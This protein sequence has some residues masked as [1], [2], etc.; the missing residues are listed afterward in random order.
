[1]SLLVIL[2]CP[3][4]VPAAPLSRRRWEDFFL[5]G[6]QDPSNAIAYWSDLSYGQYD[7]RGS[8]VVDWINIGHTQA[9]IASFTGTE[10]RNQLARWGRDA[11]AKAGVPLE[12]FRQL[13][14]GY[15]IDA[16]HGSVGGN[17][18]VLAYRDGRPF[19]PTFMH[20]EL[21][22]TLGLG[23]SSSQD[24]GTYGD[25]FDIMSAM[26]VWTFQDAQ[27]RKAG[28]GIA[29]PNVENLGWLDPSR[30]L[31]SGAT[32]RNIELVALNRP[33]VPGYLAATIRLTPVAVYLEYRESTGWD[34]ALPGPRILVHRRNAEN[35]PEIYGQGFN[36]AGALSA[37]QQ[38]SLPDSPF[39]II[40]R[41]ESMDPASSKANVLLWAWSMNVKV[42]PYPAPLGRQITLVVHARDSRTNAEVAGE[43]QIKNFTLGAPDTISFPTNTAKVLTLKVGSGRWAGEIPTGRVAAPSYPKVDLEFG[44]L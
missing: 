19:E 18:A 13:I 33:D 20:H 5:P 37:G 7:A 17:T 42:Q 35:G 12:S 34:R 22:H 15:N 10:Q 29:A 11:A 14:F 40:V 38:I 41:A 21:G 1:M 9:E 16:D 27:G 3:S 28:P 32:T 25:A 31:Q 43:V 24:G 8:R 30:V 36:P 6:G 26:N 39:T 44:F 2:C 4:D 23:H